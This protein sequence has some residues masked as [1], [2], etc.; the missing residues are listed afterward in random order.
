MRLY[1]EINQLKL[2]NFS[3]FFIVNG[4]ETKN[5]MIFFFVLIYSQSKVITKLSFNRCARTLA[6]IS[7]LF[8]SVIYRIY[9]GYCAL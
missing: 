7:S 8:Q 1:N 5:D 2:L 4:P 6:A 3:F 9:C